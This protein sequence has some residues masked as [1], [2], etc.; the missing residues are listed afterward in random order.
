M[1]LAGS[2][3]FALALGAA[4]PIASA[5]DVT[6]ITLGMSLEAV[7]AKIGPGY[8]YVRSTP[9]PQLIGYVAYKPY[10]A[11]SVQLLNDKVVFINHYHEYVPNIRP[12]TETVSSSF[13]AKYGT[14]TGGS[15]A[16]YEWLYDPAGHLIS[17][18]E[19]RRMSP[20]PCGGNETPLDFESFPQR[21]GPGQVKGGLPFPDV[22]SSQCSIYVYSKANMNGDGVLNVG[23]VDTMSLFKFTSKAESALKP[24]L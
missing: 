2:I 15:G 5:A 14:P 24:K 6:G 22:A 9:Y 17:A 8:T 20:A 18:D 10:D 3:G 19:S 7:K 16:T 23:I 21:A 13:I 1:R 4:P 11:Y 12:Q